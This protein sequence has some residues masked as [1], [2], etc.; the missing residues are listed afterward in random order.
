MTV[1]S[2]PTP[3]SAG[4]C[5]PERSLDAVRTV[6]LAAV[7]CILYVRC[8]LPEHHFV[9]MKV[10]DATFKVLREKCSEA[11]A[12]LYDMLDHG[13]YD[14]IQRQYLRKLTISIIKSPDHRD[15]SLESYHLHFSYPHPGSFTA[16]AELVQS[17]DASPHKR[18]K[19]GHFDSC[20]SG[21]KMP[22]ATQVREFMHSLAFVL[23]TL[24]SL[25]ANCFMDMHLEYN[26][27]TPQD[28][29]P[30]FFRASDIVPQ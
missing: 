26:E 20:S 16:D 17:N 27:S 11:S 12:L 23:H 13:V 8:L 7:S 14:A 3:D 5:G 22:L 2:T 24:K 4:H 25:P 6:V 10:D 1:V 18:L 9:P 15:Q 29:E 19:L 30:M 28:Y 21:S